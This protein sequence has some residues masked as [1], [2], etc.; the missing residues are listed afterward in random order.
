M[1]LVLPHQEGRFRRSMFLT[2]TS[3]HISLFPVPSNWY[4]LVMPHIAF[5]DSGMV[6]PIGTDDVISV[7][8]ACVQLNTFLIDTFSNKLI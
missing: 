4:T 6:F 7:S 2:H 8:K 1:H 3:L 5:L